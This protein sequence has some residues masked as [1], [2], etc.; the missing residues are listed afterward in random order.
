MT[1]EIQNAVN[2]VILAVLTG[3]ATVGLPAL[4]KWFNARLETDSKRKNDDATNDS[5]EETLDLE[6]RELTNKLA[7]QAFDIQARLQRL[8]AEY[9]AQ[10]EMVKTQANEIVRLGHDLENERLAKAEYS[11]QVQKLVAELA[12]SIARINQLENEIVILE[13]LRD[14]PFSD[15]DA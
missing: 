13:S 1:P 10:S 8:Q 9:Q 15:K 2:L 5:K 11:E 3:M 4:W 6:T 14:I 7:L 12:A